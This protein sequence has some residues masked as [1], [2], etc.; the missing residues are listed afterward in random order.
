VEEVS[1]PFSGKIGKIC[2]FEESQADNHDK[3]G[4]LCRNKEDLNWSSTCG[5]V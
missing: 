5:V 3:E 2:G 4:D 1:D